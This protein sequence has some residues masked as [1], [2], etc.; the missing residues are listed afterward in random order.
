MNNRPT[1]SFNTNNDSKLEKVSGDLEIWKKIAFELWKLLDDVDTA[2]D[3]F[4]PPINNFFKYVTRKSEE[5]HKFLT[6]DG[7]DIFLTQKG[8]NNINLINLSKK[9]GRNE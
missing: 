8:I 7:Y 1:M 2:G 4:K 3:I 6:T 9:G 5:R